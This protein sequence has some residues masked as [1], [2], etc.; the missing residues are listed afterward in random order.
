MSA[1]EWFAGDEV[2]LTSALIEVD[3]AVD[4]CVRLP[5]WPFRASRAFARIYEFGRVLGGDF[6]SVLA[7]LAQE[8]GDAGVDF[9]S[10]EPDA[11]QMHREH[12][13]FAAGRVPLHALSEGFGNL[14]RYSADGDPTG[15][16]S[17]A[18]DV[19][20][21]VGS[22]ATWAVWAQ[23]DWEIGV[24]VTPDDFGPWLA[25]G[26]PDFGRDVNLA[27]IR[28]PEGWVVPLGNE[29][30]DVFWRNVRARGSGSPI[31]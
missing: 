18:T 28:G 4:T 27:D 1:S 7:S 13:Y 2:G 17:I 31:H 24:L 22:S 23:R 9:L 5:N 8:Y 30:L 29:V 21:I 16:L 6:G 12:G 3:R 26:V 14:L 19:L 11:A 25:A 20:C 10:V 15:E